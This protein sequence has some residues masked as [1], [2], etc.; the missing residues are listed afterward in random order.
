[1]NQYT[2]VYRK[3]GGGTNDN[4]LPD[5]TMT[6]TSQ[7]TQQLQH[8]CNTEASMPRP[9]IFF[10]TATYWPSSLFQFSH[11]HAIHN[12]YELRSGSGINQELSPKV[13]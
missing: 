10:L 6:L 11:V 5:V 8:L 1:M 4:H 2:A 7:I 12:L 3:G 9:R 13:S